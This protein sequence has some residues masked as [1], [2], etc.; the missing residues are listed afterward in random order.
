MVTMPADTP[1]R[2]SV[3]RLISAQYS[4]RGQRKGQRAIGLSPPVS[5]RAVL[6]ALSLLPLAASSIPGVLPAASADT[7]YRF[8]TPHQA[9]VLDA[10]TRRLIPGPTDHPLEIGHPGAA[11][12]NVVGVS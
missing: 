6:G 11:E 2:H 12:A 5:R 1:R 4:A 7:G 8:L 3:L 10:A 9:A